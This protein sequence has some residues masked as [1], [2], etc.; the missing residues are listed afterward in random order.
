MKIH[1]QRKHHS[2]DLPINNY[3]NPI[4]GTNNIH[5]AY[6]F[7]PRI[8]LLPY[9][10]QSSYADFLDNQIA[11]LR[12]VVE[13]TRLT[14]ELR[15]PSSFNSLVNYST[16]QGLRLI[17]FR[18]SVCKVCL[19]SY[20]GPVLNSSEMW[21]GIQGINTLHKCD[22]ESLSEYYNGE[23]TNI[24]TEET[25]ND[26]NNILK[27]LPTKIKERA[28]DSDWLNKG[29]YLRARRVRIPAYPYHCNSED[30]YKIRGLS[31]SNEIH[32]ANRA[33]NDG[34]T[35]I[36]IDEFTDFLNCARFA[37]FGI[38]E[39]DHMINED[40]GTS[41]SPTP[42]PFMGQ[43]KTDSQYYFMYVTNMGVCT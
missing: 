32:W 43:K 26:F 35:N 1:L 23:S 27:S 41:A 30:I 14:N 25:K 10:F 13:Y 7:R 38:F 19:I 34:L 18:G 16:T 37:T 39:V 40:K 15:M 4:K 21:E 28:I 3:D 11:C 31:L 36:N 29:I 17:G 22:R 6:N 2:T 33:I 20:V 9:S 8:D 42:E 12:K 5:N 24:Q